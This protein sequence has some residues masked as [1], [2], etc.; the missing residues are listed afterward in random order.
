MHLIHARPPGI[1]SRGLRPAAELAKNRPHGDRLRYMAGC[2]CSQCRRANSAYETARAAARKAGDWN[3]NVSAD[4]AR[5]HM[6]ALATQSVG[7]RTVHAVSGIADSILVRI[8]SGDKKQIRARTERAILAVTAAAAA[9]R[10]LI[11]AAETWV[12]IDELLRD[13]YS[14]AELARQLGYGRPALQFRRTTVTV[15][16]AYEVKRLHERLRTC[17]AEHTLQ[18]LA[19]LREEGFRQ[20]RIEADLAGLAKDL[21]M[22]VPDLQVRNGLIRQDVAT[23]VAKLHVQLTE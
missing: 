22:P 7:R 2:R 9:D 8:I 18:L 17:A 11:P 19:E 5:A 4:K 15:R 1:A 23:L 21:A 14:K 16:T 20:Q 6:A 3:G 12:L 13:G 10:A